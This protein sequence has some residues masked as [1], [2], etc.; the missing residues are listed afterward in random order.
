MDTLLSF[1]DDAALVGDADGV[2]R[3]VA[4]LSGLSSDQWGKELRY[5]YLEPDQHW[6]RNANDVPDPQ[7]GGYW[8]E[9]GQTYIELIQ[10]VKPLETFSD[11]SFGLSIRATFLPNTNWWVVAD[12]DPSMDDDLEE[13]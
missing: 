11:K 2:V 10:A 8:H 3:T 9:N 4:R 12:I 5:D 6:F 7:T 13:T 1:N